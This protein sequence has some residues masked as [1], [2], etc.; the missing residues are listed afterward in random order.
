MYYR[1]HL[2]RLL[3]LLWHYCWNYGKIW[4]FAPKLRKMKKM[5]ILR[6][7]LNFRAQTA[8]NVKYVD[9]AQWFEFSRLNCDNCEICWYCAM[10]WIFAPKIRKMRKCWFCATIWIFSPKLQKMRKC[11]F[12]AIIWV[13]NFKNTRPDGRRMGE[14]SSASSLRS[15]SYFIFLTEKTCNYNLIS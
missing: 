8:K 7:D 3:L 4:I 12:C 1:T 2:R 11:W 9:I 5:L 15:H 13:M 6:N 14:A 10:I